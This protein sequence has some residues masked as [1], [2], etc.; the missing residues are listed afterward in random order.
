[1]SYLF[2]YKFYPH[3]CRQIE[4]TAKNK[5]GRFWD[6]VYDQETSQWKAR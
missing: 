6:R 1:M 2:T 3:W 4:V 5:V